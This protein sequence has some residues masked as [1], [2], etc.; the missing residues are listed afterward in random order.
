MREPM[1]VVRSRRPTDDR[2]PRYIAGP[3]GAMPS[4]YGGRGESAPRMSV[5]GWRRIMGVR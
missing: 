2:R 1:A 3:D 5:R 4:F